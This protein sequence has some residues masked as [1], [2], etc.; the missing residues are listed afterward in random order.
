MWDEGYEIWELGCKMMQDMG[1]RMWDAR[2]WL[3]WC[4][5]L[6]HMAWG[7]WE[8]AALHGI[9]WMSLVLEGVSIQE[10]YVHRP[11]VG[12]GY[13]TAGEMGIRSLPMPRSH[14]HSTERRM[15]MLQSTFP[16]PLQI[17]RRRFLVNPKSHGRDD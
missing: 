17:Q 14:E 8:L 3:A 4:A 12:F 15:G 7:H 16:F 2:S 6:A 9:I 1:C 10:S 13:V 11:D 5:V